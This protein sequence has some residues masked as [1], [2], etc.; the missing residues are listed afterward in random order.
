MRWSLAFMYNFHFFFQVEDWPY[1]EVE[2][3]CGGDFPVVYAI[4]NRLLDVIGAKGKRTAF[5]RS[6]C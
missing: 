6:S 5:H 2:A 4:I 1:E 3:D